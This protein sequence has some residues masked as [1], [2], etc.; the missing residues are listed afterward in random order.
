VV[1]CIGNAA[2]AVLLMATPA[3]AQSLGDLARQEEAR[4]AD[5]K[6]AVKTLSNA[7]LD[8][9][10]IVAPAGA[11][12]AEPSCYMS[13]SQGRCVSAEELVSASVAGT[14]TK[15]NAPY[16]QTFRQEA[17]EIR[18]QIE[19]THA[20]IATLEAV[21]ADA[22]RSPSDRKAAEKPLAS[23]RQALTGLERQWEK[24]EK[25]AGYQRVPRQWIEPIPTLTTK[26]PQ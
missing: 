19:K 4:R 16:E 7:D 8:P 23:A 14:L 11:T 6:K 12:P 24:L 21:I 26:T 9:S 15:E 17:E 13:K 20:S 5:A 10:A 3:A 25:R 2:V 22:G 1:R 18:S